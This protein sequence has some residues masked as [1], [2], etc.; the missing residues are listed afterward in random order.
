VEAGAWGGVMRPPGRQRTRGG[1]MGGEMNIINL[2]KLLS[3]LNKF[4][5]INPNKRK[6]NE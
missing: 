2:K 6:F 4:K 5:I 1:W 3:E